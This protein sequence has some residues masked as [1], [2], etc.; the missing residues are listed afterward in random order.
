LHF[1]ISPV[2]VPHGVE[3]RSRSNGNSPLRSQRWF[4][5]QTVVGLVHRASVTAEGFEPRSLD[6]RPVVGICNAWSELVHCNVHF[7]GLAQAIKRGVIEAGGLPLEFP[8]LSLSENLMKPTT[9]LYRNLMAMDVEESIRAHPLDA[10]VLLA[11]CD[12]TIAAQLMGAASAG[13][14]AIMLTGGPAQPAYFQ[15][16]RLGVGTDLWEYTAEYRAGRMSERE[17]AELESALIPSFGHCN[18][19]G[20]AST[21]A[22]IVEALGMSLPGTGAIPAVDARRAAA[23]EQTGRRAVEL[24]ASGLSPE[25]ILSP[26]AFD[27][28]ITTLTAIGGSTNAV[29]HLL[30]LAGRVGVEL[31]LAR[32]DAISRRTP[33][34]ANLRP[35]G[36]YLFEDLFRVGGV[37]A[38]LRELRPLLDETATLVT[39][40]SMGEALD[41]VESAA[42]GEVIAQLSSPRREDGGFAVLEG[43]L[44]PR[45]ALIKHVA[46]SPELLQHRGRAVV[47]ED[48]DDL[49]A[50]IDDPDLPAQPDS[51]LVLKNAGPRGAPGFPEWGMLPLPQRLLERGVRDMVRVSDARMSGTAFGTVVLHVAPEAADLGP[52]AAVEDG[53]EVVL[54][55]ERRRLDVTLPDD[56][57]KRR[58]AE[59]PRPSPAYVRGYGAMY[60]DHVLQADEGCDF[61]FLRRAPGEAPQKEPLGLLDGWIGGW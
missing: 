2:N 16:R 26:A 19:L 17:Y 52:L 27:N 11:G 13:V 24:A 35:A 20:T 3:A 34:L 31:D 49:I 60:L 59:R 58:L 15:G 55:V 6:G 30:A 57:I 14:P 36:E 53:D 45:G 56:E 61:D 41:R 32:F 48:M 21:L 40:E 12:K 9:M 8:T 22:A 39:G 10:I 33:V 18:E 37:P 44:A 4:G 28:A 47:F 46:A 50:R 43:N 23:A 7:R 38:L 51:V 5:P 54:D 1:D 29:V 42:D 25:R